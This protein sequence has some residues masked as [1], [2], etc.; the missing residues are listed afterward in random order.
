MNNEN[1]VVKMESA[2]K[3]SSNMDVYVAKVESSDPALAKEQEVMPTG[4]ELDMAAEEM[5]MR[6]LFSQLPRKVKRKMLKGNSF[7]DRMRRNMKQ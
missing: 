2:P 7:S 6:E 4:E 3:A 1:E 5:S